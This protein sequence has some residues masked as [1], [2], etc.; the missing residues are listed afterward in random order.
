MLT[1]H[2]EPGVLALLGILQSSAMAQEPRQSG[3][4]QSAA[5]T[6]GVLFDIAACPLAA[7]YPLQGSQIK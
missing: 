4:F 6:P 7:L 5:Q 3:R 2:L 1:L